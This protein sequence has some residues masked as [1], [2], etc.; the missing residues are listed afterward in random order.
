[1]PHGG[2]AGAG[3]AGARIAASV[4]V[5]LEEHAMKHLVLAASVSLAVLTAC[6]DGPIVTAPAPDARAVVSAARAAAPGGALVERTTDQFF[7]LA[8][9]DFALGL[10]TAMGATASQIAADC[11]GAL[12]E[13]AP[14]SWQSVTT[15]TGRL[16]QLVKG[17]DV[18]V[19]VWE[20]AYDPTT[21]WCAFV[22]SATLIAVGSADYVLTIGLGAPTGAPGA[23]EIN[24]R[25]QGTVT[26]IRTGQRLHYVVHSG[27]L[28]TGGGV[29]KG[30]N[31]NIQLTPLR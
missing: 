13:L 4:H 20:G 30:Y 15:P 14:S 2:R 1:M 29:D 28:A 27:S 5:D 12:S 25:A 6:S 17:E 8:T 22:E 19:L 24:L 31:N 7:A 18:P 11:A 23:T 21:P 3:A 26:E 16:N 9:S 10:T